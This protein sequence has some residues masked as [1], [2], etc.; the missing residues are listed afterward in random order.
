MNR[1]RKKWGQRWKR[2]VQ[3][4]GRCCIRQNNGKNQKYNQSKATKQ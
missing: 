4:N 3:I 2:V 1:S